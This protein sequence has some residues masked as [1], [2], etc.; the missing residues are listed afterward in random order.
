MKKLSTTTLLAGLAVLLVIFAASR[1]FRSATQENNLDK[2]FMSL[3]TASITEV[4]IQ[5]PA[6]T[7]P[8]VRIVRHEKTWEV[9]NEI[10]HEA[11]NPIAVR[12][13]LAQVADFRVLRFASRKK[14]K[15]TEFKVDE[16][17]TRVSIYHQ[18][19]MLADFYIGKLGFT[20]GA[21]MGGAFTYV[22]K[23]DENKVYTVEGFLE[24]TF[25]QSFNDW[26]DKT[27]LKTD[28]NEI[29]KIVFH[30]PLDSGFAIE[31]RDSSWY[32]GTDKIDLSKAQPLISAFSAKYMN[33]FVDGFSPPHSPDV[34][35]DVQAGSR[36]LASIEAWKNGVD[37]VLTSSQHKGIYFAS[38]GSASVSDILVSKSKVVGH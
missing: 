10:H 20:P 1:Y 3:D 14:E 38:K 13:M 36:T 32:S 28:R 7:L 30:Y 23:A 37:W 34:V 4:R 17:S 6:G 18:D 2:N 31:K 33:E 8:A 16:K 11:T 25:P 12:N 22:R 9:V 24:A 35:I 15:W 19:K 29:S 26:R 27:L 5:P 21:G